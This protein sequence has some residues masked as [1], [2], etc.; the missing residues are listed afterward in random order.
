[1]KKIMIWGI[2]KFS[3]QVFNSII[4]DKCVFQ[5]FVDSNPDKYGNKWNEVYDIFSPE[6]TLDMEIDYYLISA[7][8]SSNS[9]KKQAE[10]MGI[11]NDRI[12]CFWNDDVE[13]YDFIN[14]YVKENLILKIVQQKF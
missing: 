13:K 10:K 6:Q 8:A 2:G 11:K 7:T 9:I 5:G 3:N 1:M 12:I 4:Q 14:K